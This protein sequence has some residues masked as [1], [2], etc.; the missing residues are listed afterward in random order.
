MWENANQD[1]YLYVGDV[2]WYIK[3]GSILLVMSNNIYE[4]LPVYECIT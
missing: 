2:E 3:N 4:S 1:T